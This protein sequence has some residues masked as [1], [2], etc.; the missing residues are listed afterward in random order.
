[1]C[2]QPA[3]GGFYVGKAR[4]VNNSDDLANFKL[5]EV[6]ICDAIEPQMTFVVAIAGAIVERRGACLFME[7][8]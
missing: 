6:L 4:V 5:G 2:G 8:L 7:L 1:M 3:A